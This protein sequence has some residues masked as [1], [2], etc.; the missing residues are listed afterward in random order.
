MGSLRLQSGTLRFDVFGNHHQ[1]TVFFCHSLGANQSLWDRQTERMSQKHK[2]VRMDL[3]GHGQSD[4]FETPYSIK[5]LALDIIVL[6]DFLK[7]QKCHFVGLSLGSM[8]GLW[9]AVNRPERFN[10]MVLAGASANVCKKKPFDER[11]DSIKQK[12]LTSIV[13]ELNSRWYFSD[14]VSKNP[15]IVES[16]NA[17]VIQTSVDG[18]IAATIA[19]RDFDLSAQLNKISTPILLITGSEDQATPLSEA[20]FIAS[21][22]KKAKLSIV[23]GASHLAIV[24]KPSEFDGFLYDFLENQ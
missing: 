20:E 21:K 23:E 14:F 8:I 6:L 9:L 16:I 4:L 7:I 10:R 24:E 15:D 3:R 18:Y 1:E 22:I 2:V 13:G 11:I 5:T 19:V 12:G 17:M